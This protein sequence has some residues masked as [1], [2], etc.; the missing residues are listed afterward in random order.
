MKK[1][2]TIGLV[3]IALFIG[4][5]YGILIQNNQ[6][7]PHK[8]IKSAYRFFLK[9]DK[10]KHKYGPWSIGVYTGPS[11]LDLADSAE[12]TNPVLT[13]KDVNDVDGVFLADPF[14]LIRNEKFFLF[15]EVWNRKTDQG[16]IGYAESPDGKNWTYRKIIIDEPF[17]LSYPYVF[18]WNNDI[19]LIP[20][21]ARDISV[22]LYKATSFPEKWEYVGSILSG[23]RFADPSICRYD[24]TW[25]LFVSTP[26][27]DVL[28]LYYSDDLLKGWKLHPMSPIVKFDKRFARPGGRVINYNGKLYRFAQDDSSVYGRQLFAFEIT[29][30]S[31]NSYAEKL[32]SDKPVVKMTGTGWNAV[33]MHN[34]DAHKLKDN[35]MAVVDGRSR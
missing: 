2:L 28:N 29:E 32:A 23:Y 10:K 35:W 15:F 11:P 1:Y 14:M 19:Y 31:K 8:Y 33:G 4:I 22:R 13:A 12:I 9:S 30:L 16:D 27:N 7:F 17:H 18:E 24:N 25:Y 6:V 20:E 5:I 26:Q 3:I 21:S 34:V